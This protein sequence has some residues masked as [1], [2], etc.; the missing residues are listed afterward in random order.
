M[1]ALFRN[2]GASEE[3]IEW[4]RATMGRCLRDTFETFTEQA[5]VDTMVLPGYELLHIDQVRPN[6]RRAMHSLL[7]VLEGAAYGDFGAVM[8]DVAEMR[9]R[10]R[11]QPR[12]LFALVA[13]SEDLCGRLAAAC[14]H[15]LEE[16]IL[17]AIVSRRICDGGRQVVVDAFQKVHLEAR[18][19]V[20][21]LVGQ[22]SAPILPALPGVLVLPI[23]GAISAAR[24]RQILDALLA[25]IQRHGAHTAIL[26]ITGI[27]DAQATLPAYLRRASEATRL[28]GARLVLAGVPPDIARIIVAD[29]EGLRDVK[30]HGTLAAALVAA[31][32]PD[33]E[34]SWRAARRT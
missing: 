28:L 32:K 1:E 3:R 22:F 9:A 19:E 27:R 13:F 11:L 34:G 26:D 6:T 12:A 17:G 2:V 20:D 21:R 25:G 5:A 30:V 29:P 10:Q 8:R 14:L 24:A 33:P 23:V 16:L 31:S 4:A 15:G 7:A 18:D